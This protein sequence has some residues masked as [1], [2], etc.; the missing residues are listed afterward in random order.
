MQMHTIF[1][2]YID[3]SCTNIDNSYFYIMIAN[4]SLL[5]TNEN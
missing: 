1:R 5:I 4:E 2:E 3:Q